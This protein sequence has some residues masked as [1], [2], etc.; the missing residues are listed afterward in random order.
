METICGKASVNIGKY[1]DGTPFTNVSVEDISS[2]LETTGYHKYGNELM[3]NPRT[4]KQF[5]AS[6]FIG[7]T[8]Y[9]RLNIWLLI[10][11]IHVQEDLLQI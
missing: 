7:P 6:I 3:Y 9:Q 4:G 1:G 11:C 8:Y 5:V 10:R 2:V